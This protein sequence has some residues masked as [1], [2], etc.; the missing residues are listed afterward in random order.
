MMVKNKEKAFKYL[1]MVIFI[2]ENTNQ[3]VLKGMDNIIGKMG[4]TIEDN[5]CQE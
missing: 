2:L 5:F 4:L 3:V 1:Q